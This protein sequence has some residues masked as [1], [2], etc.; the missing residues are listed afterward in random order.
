MSRYIFWWNIFSIQFQIY[1]FWCQRNVSNA[2]HKNKSLNNH[3]NWYAK[4]HRF[5]IG[6]ETM[7]N[8]VKPNQQIQIELLHCKALDRYCECLHFLFLFFSVVSLYKWVGITCLTVFNRT[9]CFISH[10]HEFS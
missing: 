2:R 8:F 4:E 1:R 7:P 9:K 5:G 6:N 10:Q 3:R